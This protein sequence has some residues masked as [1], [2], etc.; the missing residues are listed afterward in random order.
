M[1]GTRRWYLVRQKCMV[2]EMVRGWSSGRS[3]PPAPE[4]SLQSPPPPVCGLPLGAL[5]LETTE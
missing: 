5:L 3:P 1:E 4:K 2:Y